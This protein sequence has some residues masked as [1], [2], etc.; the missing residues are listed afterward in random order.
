MFALGGAGKR[1]PHRC[2]TKTFSS[3]LLLVLCLSRLLSWL[4]WETFLCRNKTQNC[5]RNKLA[6][7]EQCRWQQNRFRVRI[8]GP[9]SFNSSRAEAKSKAENFLKLWPAPYAASARLKVTS[10]DFNRFSLLSPAFH[11]P[12][13]LY[14][15]E[16]RR[17]NFYERLQTPSYRFCVFQQPNSCNLSPR[18]REERASSAHTVSR[19][20]GRKCQHGFSGM[21]VA[22]FDVACTPARSELELDGEKSERAPLMMLKKTRKK[23]QSCWNQHRRAPS[24]LRVCAERKILRRK[25]LRAVIG[26][27]QESASS[28]DLRLPKGK[29]VKS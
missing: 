7:P 15:A 17:S 26:A 6:E 14:V 22:D 16:P 19:R 29:P 27:R 2:R 20:G 3:C 9:R 21:C 12:P 8:S 4:S 13:Q 24:A 28:R 10:C 5:T 1:L 11:A 23:S 25:S 18:E